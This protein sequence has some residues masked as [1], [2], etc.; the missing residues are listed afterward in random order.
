MSSG[1][2]AQND[3]PFSI[4]GHVSYAGFISSVDTDFDGGIGIGGDLLFLKSDNYPSLYLSYSSSGKYKCS[5]DWGIDGGV[6]EADITINTFRIGYGA[7]QNFVPYINFSSSNIEGIV[8]DYTVLKDPIE[9]GDT[10]FG[11]GLLY[12]IQ[13]SREYSSGINL[14]VEYHGSTQTIGVAV[15]FG[16]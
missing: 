6:C 3:L 2:N 12:R 8:D 1:A 4:G 10:A 11:I 16:I 5:V 13:F 14:M 15:G 7:Y 9:N